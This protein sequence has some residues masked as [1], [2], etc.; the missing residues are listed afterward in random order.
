MNKGKEKKRNDAID[1]ALMFADAACDD[2]TSCCHER[3]YACN[4]RHN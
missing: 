4:R 1:G 2:S 3:A